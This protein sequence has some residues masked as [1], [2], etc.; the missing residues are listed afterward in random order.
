VEN[1]HFVATV[2]SGDPG[3]PALAGADRSDDLCDVCVEQLLR[4]LDGAKL[5]RVR[6]HVR[7]ETSS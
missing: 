1:A 5:S 4:F 2:K 3:N 6:R 7:A